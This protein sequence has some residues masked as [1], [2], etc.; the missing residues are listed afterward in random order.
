LTL[1][2][3]GIVSVFLWQVVKGFRTGHA[4]VC[5]TV[6][7][8]PFVL[9]G[10]GLVYGVFHC[11]LAVF[12]PSVVLMLGRGELRLG[13]PVDPRWALAGRQDRVH[14]L[15]LRLEGREEATYR[16]GTDTHTDKDTFFTLDLLDTEDATQISAG[17]TTFAVPRDTVHS[18]E[19]A[20]NKVAW[21]LVV[22]GHIRGRPD[23]KDEYPLTVAPLAVA[24]VAPAPGGAAGG[25]TGNDAT[26]EATWTA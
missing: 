3:N 9:V 4:E 1:F 25:A 11:L 18:F 20:N 15:V 13:D 12:N 7:L 5:L 10:L 23:V 2:W 17:R 6:F 24:D 21:A 14:R 26:E 22:H 19:S 8:V 16:R